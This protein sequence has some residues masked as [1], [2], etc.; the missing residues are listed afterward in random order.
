MVRLRLSAF[1]FIC[2]LYGGVVSTLMPVALNQ[3]TMS[4]L[5]TS[6]PAPSHRT[7]LT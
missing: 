6:S 7:I 5:L 4:A 2:G 3:A 1:P